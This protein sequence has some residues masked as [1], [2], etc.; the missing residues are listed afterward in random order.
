MAEDSALVFIA[1][2]DS[3]DAIVQQIRGAGA[4]SVELLVPDGTPA[5]QALG[6][7]AR[8]RQSLER[9]HISLLVISSDEKTL[10]AARLNQLDTVG[11]HGA[12][13]AP[14][15]TTGNGGQADRYTTQVLPRE[16]IAP[17][18][19]EDAEFL[20]AL[21]QLPP[22]D[23]YA[24]EEDADLYAALDDLSDTFQSGT[25]AGYDS[26]RSADDEFA[27]A[28]DEWSAGDGGS[29]A[30][31]EWDIELEPSREPTGPRRRVR[32]ED[33]ELSAD[34]L[35]R[36][37]GSRRST[38][39]RVRAGGRAESRSA[40]RRS[41]P[42]ARWEDLEE[43]EEAAPRG[44]RLSLL[45][46]LLIVLLA[47]A[48]A[49]FWYFRNRTTISVFLPTSTTTEHPFKGEVIPIASGADKS[50]DAIQAT[51]IEANAEFT[52]QGQVSEETLSPAGAAKGTV[53]VINRIAQEIQLPAETQFVA[54][55]EGG[56]EVRFKLEQPVTVPAATTTNS[57]TGSSTTFGSIDVPVVALAPGNA[58][59]IGQDTIK[60]ILIPGQAAIASETSNFVLRNAPIGGGDDQPQRIVTEADVERSLQEALTGL[61]NAG[62]QALQS[63]IDPQTQGIDPVSIAPS[64]E[65]LGDPQN[66]ELV[67][68]PPVGQPVADPNKPVF[69]ITVRARFSALATPREQLVGQQLQTAVQQHFIQRGNLPCKAGENAGLELSDYRWDGNERR[70]TVDATI[71]CTPS[72]SLATETISQ[73]KRAVAGKSRAEAV[74]NLDALKQ[75]GIIDDYT[76]P[77]DRQQFPSFDFLLTVE[78]VRPAPADQP[79]PTTTP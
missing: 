11:V 75:G 13:V 41:R 27:T 18:A 73:V 4:G 51:P 31:D 29:R 17:I 6:G 50:P 59:N 32:P 61:N 63:Q 37:P 7:F 30:S 45:I 72:Q 52:V 54:L 20:D 28:L 77:P 53:T 2:S 70:L 71:T 74:Q 10:N 46:P 19:E 68:E 79:Q 5:L 66:Y 12:R 35:S 39:Q 67:A 62:I 40:P 76:L 49:A 24:G 16:T 60:Q 57:L 47:L 55:K 48:I 58:S 33:L 25:T 64:A 34:E 42:A 22:Q 56:Q 69:N 8:L 23:R 26:R 14:P 1:P 65:T 9:D 36:Q 43:D 15:A 3:V 44:W 78:Q 21:D 38:S